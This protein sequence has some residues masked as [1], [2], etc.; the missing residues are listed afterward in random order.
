MALER[1]DILVD[2]AGL[3]DSPHEWEVIEES[4]SDISFV[5]IRPRRNVGF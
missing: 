1:S 3:E 5:D 2:A 4:D